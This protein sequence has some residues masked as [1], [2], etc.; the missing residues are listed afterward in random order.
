[1]GGIVGATS[2][3]GQGSRFWMEL[4]LAKGKPAPRPISETG[5][6]QDILPL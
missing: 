6:P 5:A 3:P 1:M 4:K 2:E